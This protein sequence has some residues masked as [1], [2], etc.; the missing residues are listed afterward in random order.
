MINPVRSISLHEKQM[1][2]SR[3]NKNVTYIFCEI[4]GKEEE[5]K[6]G[7]EGRDLS[8]KCERIGEYMG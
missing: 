5:E 4:E 1:K 3:L 2:E 6:Q 8:P 7:G